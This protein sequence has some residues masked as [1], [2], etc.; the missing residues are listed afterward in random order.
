MT[1]D[2]RTLG[3]GIGGG[4]RPG[5]PSHLLKRFFTYPNTIGIAQISPETKYMLASKF[6]RQNPNFLGTFFPIMFG[7]FSGRGEG[8]PDYKLFEG[9]VWLSLDIF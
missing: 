9:L 4:G 2:R 1:S 5:H 7:H 6:R 3:G 8:L